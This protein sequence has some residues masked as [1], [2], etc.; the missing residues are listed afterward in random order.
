MN[1]GQLLQDAVAETGA[2][3]KV[4]A[5]RA[6]QIIAQEAA[7]LSLA[8]SEPGFEMVLRASRDNVALKLGIEASMTAS[9][10]DQRLLGII[11][12]GLLMIATA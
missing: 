7:V 4:S 6:K 3:L 12:T 2:Q 1:L 11:Q 5:G 8:S 9:A 10:A